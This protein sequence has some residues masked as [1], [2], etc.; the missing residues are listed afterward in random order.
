MVN[1]K[2]KNIHDIPFDHPLIKALKQTSDDIRLFIELSLQ[3]NDDSWERWVP[4]VIKPLEAR[5]WEIKKCS[6]KDCPAYLKPDGRCWLV[7]GTMCKGNVQGE[8]A[9]KYKSCTECEVYR[10]SVYGDPVVEIYEHLITLVHSLKSTQD[11]LKTMA[12]RDL[13]TGV[14]N[15]NYFNETIA[16]EIEKAKR[17]GE[18]LSIIMV[19]IDNFKNI[20]DTYG[21]LH[22]DG[23][24]KECAM[25][26]K[27]AVRTSDFLCRF[28]GD[29]FLIFTPENVCPGNNSLITR[30][31]DN[32]AEW[33]KKYSSPDY[34]L[35]LSIGCS[36]WNGNRNL[37]DV[38][39]EADRLM[40]ENKIKKMD[41]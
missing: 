32:V 30:I 2:S 29:E 13:L 5:C 24:L 6:K 22:G 7:A 17:Y 34:K 27:K 35:S 11:K 15:R 19:D 38:I 10:E 31:H 12:T 20:N 39:N 36:V 8:F 14:Y 18:K 26:L 9:L 33:N 16:R 1:K 40:Y 28:G 3:E 23:I 21:H 4:L 41:N 37:T 25:I